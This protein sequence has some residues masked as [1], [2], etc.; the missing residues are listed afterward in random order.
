MRADDDS[1][2][3]F[4]GMGLTMGIIGTTILLPCLFKSDREWQTE[5]V[6]HGA[7][8]W[9]LDPKTGATTWK[10]KDKP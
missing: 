3:A 9:V 7:A 5:A 4:F 6:E 8:E 2:A 1:P 10:W